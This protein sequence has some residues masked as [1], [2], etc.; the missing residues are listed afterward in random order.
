[1]TQERPPP[2]PL[3]HSRLL[4]DTRPVSESTAQFSV[5]RKSADAEVVGAIERL[6]RDA[7]DRALARINVFAFAAAEGL[8][9]E[10]VI[11]G[12]LHAARLGLFDLSWNVLCPG[13][14]GVLDQ[15]S[16]L[17]TVD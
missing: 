12:F 5:L 6:V 14:G 2:R 9:P 13:C 7:P 1:M 8:D 3:P 16:T 11:T 17:K 10:R 4:R 15:G